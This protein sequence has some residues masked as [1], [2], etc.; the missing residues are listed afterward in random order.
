MG[1]LEQLT[2]EAVRA[3]STGADAYLAEHARSNRRDRDGWLRDLPMN[4]WTATM[5]GKRRFWY[6]RAAR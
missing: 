6:G 1:W 4:M 2:Q 3:A 5:A